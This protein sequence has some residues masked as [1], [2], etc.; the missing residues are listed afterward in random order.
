MEGSKSMV[1]EICQWL[2]LIIYLHSNCA[3]DCILETSMDIGRENLP[4][5]D[6]DNGVIWV[7]AQSNAFDDAECS[8]DECKVGR[9]LQRITQVTLQHA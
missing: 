2:T 3:A 1:E 7:Y 9:N 8:E 5:A 6:L 4:G